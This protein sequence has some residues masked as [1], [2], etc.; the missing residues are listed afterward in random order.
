MGLEDEEDDSR[1]QLDDANMDPGRDDDSTDD[2]EDEGTRTS[3]TKD[4]DKW[5]VKLQFKQDGEE[6]EGTGFYVN[7]PHPTNYVILTAG[8]NLVG[9]KR[10]DL[11]I[12]SES[13]DKPYLKASAIYVSAAYAKKMQ[14]EDDYGVILVPKNPNRP[15]WGFGFA[16]KRGH[17]DLLHSSL[18]LYGI[19]ESDDGYEQTMSNGIC[20]DCMPDQLEYKLD[21][22]KGFSGSPVIMPYKDLDTAVAI[23]NYGHN[24]NEAARGS[25]INE[26]ML[27]EICGWLNIG[28]FSKA[29]QASI[30]NKVRLDQRLYLIF[31]EDSDRAVVRLGYDE[32]SVTKFDILPAYAPPSNYDFPNDFRYTFRLS[33]KT[34]SLPD[35]RWVLWNADR[36]TVS[37][38]SK[39]R[40]FCAATLLEYKAPKPGQPEM[41]ADQKF[42]YIHLEMTNHQGESTELRE[43]RMRAADLTARDLRMKT[44]ET[45][46][47]FFARHKRGKYLFGKIPC[48]PGA[49]S[50]PASE[51]EELDFNLFRFFSG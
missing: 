47:I 38:T 14:E 20:V 25:R 5:V 43:L 24:L 36:H 44:F 4:R 28:F 35:E 16:L 13:P 32:E 9:V 41:R 3:S 49:P 6:R 21:T 37:L 39:L 18:V 22:N 1:P 33:P 19:K 7:M 48:K 51:R 42:Y 40:G 34:G 26:K 46:E 15:Y 11:K 31:I 10:E 12:S 17:D 2:E 45:P 50:K 23:H 29:I 8:H 30:T 27:N